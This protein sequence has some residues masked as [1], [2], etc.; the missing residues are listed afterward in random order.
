MLYRR[1]FTLQAMEKFDHYISLLP[2]E[3]IAIAGHTM[4]C[5]CSFESQ[6][7]IHG[8]FQSSI[9]CHSYACRC[10]AQRQDIS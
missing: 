9:L 5:F 2:I 4:G 3:E 8:K 7:A 10:P 1:N 6:P